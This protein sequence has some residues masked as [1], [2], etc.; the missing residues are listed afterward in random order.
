M[1][2][3]RQLLTWMKTLS[4]DCSIATVRGQSTKCNK[5][6]E[7]SGP[8]ARGYELKLAGQTG[9]EAVGV[10][11]VDPFDIAE[12][13]QEHVEQFGIEVLSPMLGHEIDGV[14]ELECRFVDPC[15]RERIEGVGD[16]CDTAFDGNGFSFELPGIAATVPPLVM[17]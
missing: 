16:R 4:A 5:F 6:G 2:M 10:L 14:I 7:R 15:G 8:E 1:A 3:R 11:F 13:S 9:S 12:G 17:G